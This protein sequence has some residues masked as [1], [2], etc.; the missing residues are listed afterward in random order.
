MALIMECYSY[1][2]HI[3]QSGITLKKAQ[4]YQASK[5]ALPPQLP[6]T[7]TCCATKPALGSTRNSCHTSIHAHPH[8]CHTPTMAMPLHLLQAPH[9]TATRNPSDPT[10]VLRYLSLASSSRSSTSASTC[11]MTALR[12]RHRYVCARTC[13]C[14]RGWQ[15][16]W[17]S[18]RRR[19]STPSAL[20]TCIAGCRRSPAEHKK[21]QGTILHPPLL[22]CRLLQS[23][24]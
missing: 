11:R 17:E 22:H 20:K 9:A 14:G 16:E 13:A 7:R 6:H 2:Q 8:T 12:A 23:P 15:K 19:A 10:A 24:D 18:W 1:I 21:V 3:Q 5:P 4:V